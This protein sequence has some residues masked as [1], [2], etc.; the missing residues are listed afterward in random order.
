MALASYLMSVIL[1]SIQ[2]A[3]SKTGYR[4]QYKKLP[5]RTVDK[6]FQNNALPDN[7]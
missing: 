1:H 4:D 3:I 5:F 7:S 6:Y 2:T